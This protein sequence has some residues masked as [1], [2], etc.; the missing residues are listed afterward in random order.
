M[1]GLTSIYVYVGPYRCP[2]DVPRCKGS[3]QVQHGQVFSVCLRAGIFLAI[4]QTHAPG[5]ARIP[6]VT[7]AQVSPMRP[8]ASAPRIRDMFSTRRGRVIRATAAVCGR[9]QPRNGAPRGAPFFF[10]PPNVQRRL[11]A[12]G[13]CCRAVATVSTVMGI[14][15]PWCGASAVADLL[16]GTIPLERR[17]PTMM[18]P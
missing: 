6:R 16:S 14:R 11:K 1:S 5:S 4:P 17:R 3:C 12:M 15:G 9:L 13:R 10:R 18:C 8:V 2:R 7:F